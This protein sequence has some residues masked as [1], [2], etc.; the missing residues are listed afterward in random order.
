VKNEKRVYFT[1][2]KRL[3][4]KAMG[5]EKVISG[6]STWEKRPFDLKRPHLRVSRAMT[7][8][9]KKKKAAEAALRSTQQ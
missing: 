4:E 3:K 1:V 7:A 9:W 8:Y 2:Y 6:K 5:V